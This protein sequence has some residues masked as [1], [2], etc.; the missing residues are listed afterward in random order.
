MPLPE[1]VHADGA[2]VEEGSIVGYPWTQ[3]PPQTLI[4]AGSVIRAGAIVYAGAQLGER[5]HVAHGALV[6]QFS[7]VG[8][9][10]SIGSRTIVEHQVE[11]GR[12]VRIHSG[13]FV[14][15]LTVIEDD[16]WLGPMVCVTNA[17]YP[18]MGPKEERLTPVRI[19]SGAKIGAG[20]VLL[21]GITIGEGALVGAGAVVTGDVE[22]GTVVVG[23][24]A[25]VAGSVAEI[26]RKVGQS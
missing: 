15:E 8:D 14:S 5:V 16:A 18:M 11:I 9:D 24:P 6:R 26:E 3:P 25:R 10:A 21:P 13:A 7:R 4:G 20:A 22:P 2:R 17:R 1:W 12:R 23:N 19:R